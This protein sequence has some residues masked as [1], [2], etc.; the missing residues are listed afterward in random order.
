MSRCV[1][2]S[3]HDEAG[4]AG[5]SSP[6]EIV[7]QGVHRRRLG[8]A[9]RLDGGVQRALQ[10]LLV[11]VMPVRRLA[12]RIPA[13]GVGGKHPE[14]A[15]ALGGPPELDGER[16]RQ[17]DAAAVVLAIGLPESRR[18]LQLPAQRRLEGARQHDDAVLAALAVAHD[19]H[20]AHEVDVLHAQPDP[21]E[22]AHARAVEEAREQAGLG[23]LHA[24]EERLHLDVGKHHRHAALR[25]RAAELLEPRQVDA[26]HF[27]IEEQQRAQRLP[28]R[29]RG[30]PALVGQ[31][32]QVLL[33]PLASELA[34]MPSPRPAHEV[35]H[36]IDIGLL[37]P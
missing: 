13:E 14:P 28:M 35:A 7:A 11:E 16:V 10:A 18:L 24:V 22:Q 12:A 2:H 20:L 8:D 34:W 32:D 29:G 30:D 21:F 19:D 9:G 6:R 4:A 3:S 25:H 1:C 15:P 26:E 5:H 33:H 36:P 23:V 31:H 37:G 27:A 17:M